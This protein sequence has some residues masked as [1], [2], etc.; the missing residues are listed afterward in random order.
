MPSHAL[1][2]ALLRHLLT[3]RNEVVILD[4][5]AGT[6]H[7]GRRTAEY[8]DVMLVVADANLK[9]L[10][11]G[12]NIYNLSKEM[13]VKKAFIVGNKVLGSFEEEVIKDYCDD[14]RVP[15]LDLIPYDEEIRK[16]DVMGKILDLSNESSGLEVIRKISEKL[17]EFR[18][19]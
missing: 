1:V 6:A 12:K 9:S 10:E 5:V 15:L 18:V 17:L 2:R 14:N 3:R 7:F 13:G 8:V 4:M 16:N 19:D 11:T